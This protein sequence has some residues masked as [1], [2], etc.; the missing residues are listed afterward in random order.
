MSFDKIT[1]WQQHFYACGLIFVVR[2]I[3]QY[4]VEILEH[5]QVV[6]FRGF[7]DAVHDSAGSGTGFRRMEQECF[8]P[9]GIALC[10]A[11]RSIVGNLTSSVKQVVTQRFPV[12]PGIIYGFFQLASSGR[13]C[14]PQPFP[15][16]LPDGCLLFQTLFFS[17]IIGTVRTVIFEMGIGTRK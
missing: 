17:F 4:H 11:L 1:P 5:V 6:A 12:I 2:H 10:A 9:D 3:Q 16:A 13:R 7:D 14:V 8:P 15:E